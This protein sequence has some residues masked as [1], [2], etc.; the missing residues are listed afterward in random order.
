MFAAAEI[1]AYDEDANPVVL[2]TSKT[3]GKRY[4]HCGYAYHKNVMD[5]GILYLRCS[6]KIQQRCYAS[7]RINREGIFLTGAAPHICNQN[8]PSL[9]SKFI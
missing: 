2:N 5:H 1:V 7:A 4:M 3:R 9:S 8:I 6:L